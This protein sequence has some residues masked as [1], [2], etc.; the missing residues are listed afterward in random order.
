MIEDAGSGRVLGQPLTELGQVGLEGRIL[1]QADFEFDLA[2]RFISLVD[3]GLFAG[4]NS[5]GP[6]GYGISSAAR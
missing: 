4:Q 6:P 1:D 3:L 5:L 2:G